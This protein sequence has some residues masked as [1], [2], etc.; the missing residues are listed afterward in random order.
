MFIFLFI[1]FS[2][3]DCSFLKSNLCMLL[4]VKV[5]LT[6]KAHNFILKSTKREERTFP[7]EFV[8]VRIPNFIGVILSK[9]VGIGGF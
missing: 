9:N 4:L 5:F 2:T 6:K 1:P 3:K 7:L 8:F